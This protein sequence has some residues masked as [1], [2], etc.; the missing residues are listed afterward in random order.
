MTPLVM[1]GSVKKPTPHYSQTPKQS[2][3]IH[4]HQPSLPLGVDATS[5]LPVTPLKT[6][7][8]TAQ[9]PL[10][11][12]T[13]LSNYTSPPP[14][15]PKIASNMNSSQA[16]ILGLGDSSDE[17]F[18]GIANSQKDAD[19][20]PPGISDS[21]DEEHLPPAAKPLSYDHP[22][23]SV[24]SRAPILSAVPSLHS[25]SGMS[26][27]SIPP[28]PV[29]AAEPTLDTEKEKQIRDEAKRIR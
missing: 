13:P 28:T 27:S 12:N 14:S 21:S 26:A 24:E 25:H 1:P 22:V 5:N 6:T 9:L 7:S 18:V 29:G 10:S 11:Q 2:P 23:P 3:Y 4:P 15:A 8:N 20:E 19:D 16:G 17:S